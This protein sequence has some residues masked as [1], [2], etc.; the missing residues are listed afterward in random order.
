MKTKVRK[1]V[2]ARKR[3][4]YEVGFGRPPKATQFK[5]GVSGNKKGRPKGTKNIA[6]LF[7]QEMHQ[8]V[9]ITENGE[10]RS[11]TKVEAAL[12][13][14]INRAATGEPK[15]IHAVISIA[16]ELGDLRL[17]DTL[18]QPESQT[19]TL[20][21]FERDPATGERVLVNSPGSEKAD[22]DE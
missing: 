7:H 19:F 15:A 21:I 20:R 16:R 6:T 18:R 3:S 17:P 8:R 4:D 13:Q 2:Q 10:R 9:A 12:K 11:I 1:P 14:L 5:K 22:D